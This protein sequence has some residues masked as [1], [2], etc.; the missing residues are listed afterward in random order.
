MKLPILPE[1]IKAN[2]CFNCCIMHPTVMMRADLL[3]KHNL[4]Y[5]PQFNNSED[6]DLWARC[7]EFFEIA[8]I[9]LPLLN[10]RV[11]AMSISSAKKDEQRSKTIKIIKRQLGKY[12]GTDL[13][14]KE[15][16]L[17]LDEEALDETNLESLMQLY[18]RLLSLG[19]AQNQI[20]PKWCEFYLK[21]T[22]FKVL[23]AKFKK[24]RKVLYLKQIFGAS[25]LRSF[26]LA[27]L[28][29]YRLKF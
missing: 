10:Y 3:K 24:T 5:D 11:H 18:K 1:E 19:K 4:R 15:L 26:L 12:F 22:I 7:S 9:P 14:E 27:V 25:P 29:F 16:L 2:L 8:N 6:F 17:L 23:R 13:D 21:K 28:N 20:S